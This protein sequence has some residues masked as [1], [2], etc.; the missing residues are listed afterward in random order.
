MKQNNFS[1]KSAGVNSASENAYATTGKKTTRK[2]FEVAN[3]RMNNE[4]ILKETNKR[5]MFLGHWQK[6]QA[7]KRQKLL[8]VNC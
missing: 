8:R 5:W 4:K 2:Q 6:K 7:I 3:V 1:K